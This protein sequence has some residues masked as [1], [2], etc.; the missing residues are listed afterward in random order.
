MDCARLTSCLALR[1]ETR[2]ISRRYMRTESSVSGGSSRAAVDPVR[3]ALTPSRSSP[4]GGTSSSSRLSALRR[5]RA[6]GLT[7]ASS[8]GEG[9]GSSRSTAPREA[10]SE[11]WRQGISRRSRTG[12]RSESKSGAC[13]PAAPGPALAGPGLAT[14]RSTSRGSIKAKPT[15]PTRAPSG[16]TR[17]TGALADQV[18]LCGLERIGHLAIDPD[19]EHS[20][21]CKATI[22]WPLFSCQTW[23]FQRSGALR[24]RCIIWRFAPPHP[25]YP[26]HYPHSTF[27]STGRKHERQRHL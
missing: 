22:A 20:H 4:T 7:R 10:T 9:S 26:R 23:D 6:A 15:P 8:R 25:Y 14:G 19:S 1:S 24:G 18:R 13:P 21:H 17:K 16:H 11:G 3:A 5:S 12:S 27:L 2:P